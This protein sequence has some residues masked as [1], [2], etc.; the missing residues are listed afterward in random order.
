MSQDEPQHEG[1]VPHILQQGELS[2]RELV[3]RLWSQDISFV[4]TYSDLH[5]FSNTAHFLSTAAKPHMVKRFSA[6]H[7]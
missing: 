7:C 1:L 6:H 3:E 2:E 5:E 4:R